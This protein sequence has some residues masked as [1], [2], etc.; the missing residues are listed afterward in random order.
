MSSTFALRAPAGLWDL[1]HLQPRTEVVV[2][3]D[4]IPAVF[5]KAVELRRDKVW[6][7][8]KEFGIWRS[9]TW[10]QTAEAVRE[11][12]G[13]LIKSQFFQCIAECFCHCGRANRVEAVLNRGIGQGIKQL[14]QFKGDVGQFRLQV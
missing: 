10:G 11:I 9:W 13:G 12:A 8:Q 1:A 5:W 2:P 3:G 4:T 14:A 6:M 7:R